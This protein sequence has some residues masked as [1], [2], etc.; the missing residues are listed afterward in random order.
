MRVGMLGTGAGACRASA[1]A[2]SMLDLGPIAT[3]RGPETYLL[4]WLG[5]ARA[6]GG[7]YD[8]NVAIARGA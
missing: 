6:L 8:F 4:L 3:A 1:G 5:M 2:T 7:V